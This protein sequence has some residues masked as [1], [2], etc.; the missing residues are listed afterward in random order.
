MQ[1]KL[2]AKQDKF[3]ALVASGMEQANAYREAYNVKADTSGR[4]VSKMASKTALIPHIAAR[5]AELK[6]PVVKKMV[7]ESALT[8]ESHLL[9]L[10][11][12][13]D[14]AQE[15]SKYDAAVR[16]EIAR[17]KAAGIVIEKR[18][19]TGANGGPFQSFNVNVNVPMSSEE[20]MA[21]A[22]RRGL[23]VHIFKK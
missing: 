8:L 11:E 20:L 1:K 19:I 22:A 4:V 14:E 6:A 23:P 15:K 2:T 10:A 17:G 18:E 13:R 21:E 5:I 7:E 9:K 12:L 3:A 16:A